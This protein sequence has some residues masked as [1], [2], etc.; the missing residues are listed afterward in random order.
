MDRDSAR[1]ASERKTLAALL[2]L[3]C[4]GRHGGG[5][6]LCGG[7]RELLEYAETKLEKCRFGNAKPRCSQCAV[8]CYRPAMRERIREVMKFAGPR[9]VTRHPILAVRHLAHRA[10]QTSPTPAK[11]PK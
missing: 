10:P 3:Y 8:H 9:M 7:C 5:R 4:R 11:E 6:E 1:F 2:G